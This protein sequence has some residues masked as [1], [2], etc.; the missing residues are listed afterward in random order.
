M[1]PSASEAARRIADALEAAGIPYG[2]G[3]ALALGVWGFPR[4]TKDVDV[5]AT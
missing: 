5:D 4:A 3:G 1:T 2:I